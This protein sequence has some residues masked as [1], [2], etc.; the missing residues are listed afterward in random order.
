MKTNRRVVEDFA[1]AS[2]NGPDRCSFWND[3]KIRPDESVASR[4]NIV[5]WTRR[6]GAKQIIGSRNHTREAYV[7]FQQPPVVRGPLSKWVQR[8]ID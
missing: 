7:V 6:I 3:R 5:A 1:V 4:A 8:A 2:P